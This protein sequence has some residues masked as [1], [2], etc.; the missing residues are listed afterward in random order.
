MPF[1]CFI[2]SLQLPWQQLSKVPWY[3]LNVPPIKMTEELS[4]VV[5]Y[6]YR[7][8]YNA[9]HPHVECQ[10]DPP[11][12]L[13]ILTMQLKATQKILMKKKKKDEKYLEWNFVVVNSRT[14]NKS[15]P[16]TRVDDDNRSY[17]PESRASP[18]TE[19][20][21][22]LLGYN[23]VA[24]ATWA[25]R[26]WDTHRNDNT[27]IIDIRSAYESIAL[28]M[29]PGWRWLPLPLQ[30]NTWNWYF[31]PRPLFEGKPPAPSSIGTHRAMKTSLQDEAV[32]F[33]SDKSKEDARN[34][35]LPRLGSLNET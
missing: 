24:A 2:V 33:N 20:A 17:S 3:W 26:R 28:R 4:S 34:C 16:A 18:S 8:T 27:V 14:N 25:F 32:G 9:S 23:A 29:S 5:S 11:P 22:P 30:K 13:P 35:S 19:C 7:Y 31:I 1:R 21:A 6:R 12:R 10:A 15:K